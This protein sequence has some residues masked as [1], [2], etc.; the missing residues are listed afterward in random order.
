[1]QRNEDVANSAALVYTQNTRNLAL[2][3]GRTVGASL[4]TQV[5]I[6]ALTQAQAEDD[7]STVPGLVTGE[8]MAQAVAAGGGGGGGGGSTDRIVLLD[9]ETYSPGAARNFDFTEDIPA[10]HL[11][12]FEIVGTATGYAIMLSDD[13]L[14]LTAQSGGPSTT[15]NSYAMYTRNHTN[16]LPTQNQGNSWN[17]WREDADSIYFRESR[18]SG[19][20]LTI[21]ATPLGGGT[22]GGQQAAAG[23]TLVQRNIIT[24]RTPLAEFSFTTDWALVS[25]TA[26]TYTAIPK[27]DFDRIELGFYVNSALHLSDC[28]H[29]RDGHGNGAYPRPVDGR[30]GGLGYYPW[31]VPDIQDGYRTRRPRAGAPESQVWIH[32][33]SQLSEPLRGFSAHERQRRCRLGGCR[34]PCRL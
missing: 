13:L 26:P 20:T 18:G 25:G 12:T 17:V 5:V 14:A 4:S 6:P 15:A 3:I 1:M 33:S 27:A 8:L 10:R 30:P 34:H 7:A 19:G 22:T 2:T 32:A 24:S 28:S 11:L 31:S 9:G 29:P 23:R 16:S 21:T